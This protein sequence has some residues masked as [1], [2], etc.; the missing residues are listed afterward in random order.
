MQARAMGRFA[1]GKKPLSEAV[2]LAGDDLNR[3]SALRAGLHINLENPLEVLRPL[4]RRALLGRCAVFG[5]GW[6]CGLRTPTPTGRRD[7]G[8]V[9]ADR[10]SFNGFFR[11]RRKSPLTQT[12]AGYSAQ[13]HAR[14]LR[15][16]TACAARKTC[17]RSRLRC[18]SG[19]GSGAAAG[20]ARPAGR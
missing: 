4:H 5:L 13:T 16:L 3:S 17:G 2:A 10:F 8:P 12:G 11:L 6:L 1:E 15:S 14:R 7:P 18:G 19:S 20:R 9:R